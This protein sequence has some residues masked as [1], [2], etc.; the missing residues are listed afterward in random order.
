MSIMMFNN[1]VLT[2]TA[3][4]MPEV[5]GVDSR[6]PYFESS[7]VDTI[8]RIISETLEVSDDAEVEAIRI[9]M[10]EDINGPYEGDIISF[11]CDFC[12]SEERPHIMSLDGDGTVVLLTQGEYLWDKILCELTDD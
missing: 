6:I 3:N 10:S 12:R 7:P 8:L 4:V 9:L 11:V 1:E 2:T 5:L